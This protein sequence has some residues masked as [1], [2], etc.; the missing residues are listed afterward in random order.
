MA[1]LSFNEDSNTCCCVQWLCCMSGEGLY[2]VLET[3]ESGLLAADD[4]DA[5]GEVSQQESA[6]T[7]PCMFDCYTVI[8]TRFNV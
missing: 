4:V 8:L 3:V 5:D 7:E 2:Q 6:T 1:V